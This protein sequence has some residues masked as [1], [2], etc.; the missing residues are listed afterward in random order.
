MEDR[1]MTSTNSGYFLRRVGLTLSIGV[2]CIALFT[3]ARA[4]DLGNPLKT[5]T[6]SLAQLDPTN[7][8]SAADKLVDK[9]SKEL[10]KVD[11]GKAIRDEFERAKRNALS[12]LPKLDPGRIL[13]ELANSLHYQL[14]QLG[15]VDSHTGNIDLSGTE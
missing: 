6:D 8:G 9:A 11:P 5:I 7:P 12:G 14:S 13:N 1:L 10:A 4:Y 2:L 3:E 15:Q